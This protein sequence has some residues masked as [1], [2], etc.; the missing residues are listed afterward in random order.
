MEVK[1][2]SGE[3]DIRIKQVL[4]TGE[5]LYKEFIMSASIEGLAM[6]GVDYNE[7]GMDFEEWERMELMVPPPPHLYADEYEDDH[8]KQDEHEHEHA[9]DDDDDSGIESPKAAIKSLKG[10]ND[11]IKRWKLV[12][13]MIMVITFLRRRIL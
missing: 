3:G 13:V 11:G 2:K 8:Y 9:F 4:I 5:K 10:D 12:V 6:A 7:W 1:L